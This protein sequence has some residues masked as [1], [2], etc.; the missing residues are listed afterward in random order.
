MPNST[1][2][3][4]GYGGRGY[5]TENLPNITGDFNYIPR[6]FNYFNASGCFRYSNIGFYSM[7]GGSLY[8][9]IGVNF[10][11]NNSNPKY[12]STNEVRPLTLRTNI[13]IKY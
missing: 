9:F 3:Y 4:L 11:A 6:D 10:N 2:R 13:I 8:P 12:T 7:V 1:G 5:L